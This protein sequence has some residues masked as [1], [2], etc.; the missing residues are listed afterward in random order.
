MSGWDFSVVHFI[1]VHQLDYPMWEFVWKRFEKVGVLHLIHC[2][3]TWFWDRDWLLESITA[4]GES[5]RSYIALWL[6]E[7][8]FGWSGKNPFVL[9]LH[10]STF[11]LLRVTSSIMHGVAASNGECYHPQNH[12]FGFADHAASTWVRR[13]LSHGHTFLRNA[14]G[15]CRYSY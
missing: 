12:R 4:T 13:K 9:F 3:L 7:R 1:A 14:K 8:L 15:G 2:S 10:G 11:E 5:R 6:C